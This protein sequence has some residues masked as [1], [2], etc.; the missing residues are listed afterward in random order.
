M[1]GPNDLSPRPTW[2]RCLTVMLGCVV[3]LTAPFDLDTVIQVLDGQVQAA[4]PLVIYGIPDDNDDEDNLV[5]P[6]PPQYRRDV[7][8]QLRLCGTHPPPQTPFL[9]RHLPRSRSA[10]RLV[11]RPG[12]EHAL[13]NGCGTPLLC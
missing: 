13:R 6:T 7:R 8:K 1:S 5:R 9:A 2:H 3:S 12:G 11:L 10:P 4:L